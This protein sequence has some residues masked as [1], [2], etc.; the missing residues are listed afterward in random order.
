MRIAFTG[1]GTAG[2]LFPAIAV[3][4]Q[5]RHAAPEADLLFIGTRKRLDAEL[6]PKYG[7]PYELI[8][9]EGFPYGLSLKAV[10]SAWQLLQGYRQARRVL[11]RFRPQAVF[12]AGGYVAAAVIPAA[13]SLGIPAIIH[14]SDALPD[15]ANRLLS[16]WATHITVSW[17]AAQAHFPAGHTECTGQPL[18]EELFAVT[19]EEAYQRLA[20]QPG[21]FT[22]LV[23][24]GSQGARRLNEA[25]LAA[26]PELLR[27]DE[28][29]VLHLTGGTDYEAVTARVAAMRAGGP[30][31]GLT[32]YHGLPY[33]D[34]MGAA[35]RAADLTVMRCGASSISE[36]AAFGLPMILVPYPHA[37]GH[38]RLNAEPLAEAG[39]GVLID[40]ADFTGERLRDE[41]T[42]LLGDPA[43]LA[44]M[45][46][47]SAGCGRPDAAKRIAEIV[48]EAA[49]A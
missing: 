20:L 41:V 5:V 27:R 31:D 46:A 26:L 34:D 43:R 14:A 19:R 12:A 18:R 30:P 4:Q 25:L 36:A 10:S 22:L 49:R 3:A 7:Y 1:G 2:H 16:R 9:S 38:Q 17:P 44:G 42:R 23:T 32:R 21:L 48:L 24:G 40:D 35:M 37:G 47:A 8:A 6:L 33:L 11:K 28:V 13:R 29:Q 39:A 45:R 15:R